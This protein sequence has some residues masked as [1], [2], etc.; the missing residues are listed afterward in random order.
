MKKTLELMKEKPNKSWWSTL[1]VG[2]ASFL[3]GQ[4]LFGILVAP[5]LGALTGEADVESMTSYAG[6]LTG[7][8]SFG[9]SLFLLM[10]YNKKVNKRD[11]AA[12]GFA[13]ES[14][15]KEYGQG[16]L[17]GLV[18]IVTVVGL[19]WILGAYSFE[20][21]SKT[22]WLAI[23]LFAVGFALQ[24]M[25]EE[26]ICRGYV[27]SSIASR[28]GMWP[29][30]MA[31]SI[32]FTLLHAM[33]P[34]LSFFSILNLFLFGLVFSL[35]Y[36]LTDSIWL[37]GAAHSIWNFSLGPVLGIAVSGNRLPS[38]ILVGQALAGKDLLSGGSFGA[39]ASILTTAF[40]ILV[41]IL[42]YLAIRKKEA[43]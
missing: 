30:L 20:V 5:L 19:A 4:I 13:T 25:T 39:E 1:L 35:L 11:H 34:N 14:P 15:L 29:G 43:K 21:S 17:A 42:L 40:G 8:F 37:V 38:T 7:L 16:I 22:N 28:Y 33:N 27:Q 9:L 24:G 18:A 6:S 23:L 12:L 10:A 2:A 41:C 3:L 36:W 31:S 32:F 26:V